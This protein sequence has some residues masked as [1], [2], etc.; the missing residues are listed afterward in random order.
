MSVESAPMPASREVA[1]LTPD[2]RDGYEVHRA[3]LRHGLD[4][5][6]YP[7]QVMMV[8]SADLEISFI[9]GIP[10]S[11]SLGA[12][13]FAQ[14]KRMRRALME[15]AE[16]PVPKGATFSVG[17]GIV[18]AK[19]FIER[20][21]YPVVVKPAM[22]DN[23]IE[24]FAGVTDEEQL[25]AAI[26]FLRTPPAERD[27]FT[28]A[29]YALTELREPGEED[30]RVV[31]P[32]GYRFLIEEHLR[33][34]YVRFLV[35]DGLVRSV[36]H[37]PGTPASAWS[38][39]PRDI[40]GE[41]H[42]TLL[43]MA[44]DAAKAMPGLT[45][46]A[47]DM[48]VTDH[49]RPVHE[50]SASIVEFSERPG[51]AVQ[52]AVSA[53]LSGQ[54]GEILLQHGATYAGIEVPEPRDEVAVEFHAEAI[55]DLDGTVAAIAD[56]ARQTGLAGHIEITDRVDGVAQGFIQGDAG[57]IARLGESLLDG[58]LAGHRA[59]LVDERQA[60]LRPDEGPMRVA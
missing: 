46:S 19:R 15:R 42:P 35:M 45:V 3:A 23:A 47:V 40:I 52:A 1:E 53:E 48:V 38:D 2:V 32:P 49:R 11:T 24:V 58:R 37:C 31:V 10:L 7:R 6:L 16:L 27:T 5:V 20:I 4:V 33:G 34:E 12:V 30:G 41:T 13:T 51:L 9:H 43:Q 54:L 17:R 21:G 56:A 25:E 14:D 55:P 57:S 26:D 29:A 22:G 36:V 39:S 28:R 60:E 18:D 8:S 44:L 50:Q 59:M